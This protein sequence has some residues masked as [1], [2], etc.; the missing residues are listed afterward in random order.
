M[1]LKDPV[2]VTFT[3][4]YT[5]TLFS[6]LC[7]EI[8]SICH[9]GRNKHGHTTLTNAATPVNTMTNIWHLQPSDHSQGHRHKV[10]NN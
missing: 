7:T 6:T 1:T 3:R 8:V 2:T 5:H 9:L 10:C 4:G